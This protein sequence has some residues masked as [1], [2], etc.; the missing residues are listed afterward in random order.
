MAVMEALALLVNLLIGCV[1][2][3]WLVLYVRGWR[4]LRR[5]GAALASVYRLGVFLVATTLVALALFSPMHVLY[6]QYLFIR[7]L[8]TVILYL[9]AAPAFF[10]SCAYDVMLW[11]LPVR[12]R[13]WLY[14]NV[15]QRAP[16]GHYVRKL[17]PPGVAWLL[18]VAAFVI[19]QEPT[20]VNWSVGQPVV[21]AIGLAVVG[22]LALLFWWQIAGSGPRLHRSLLP[23]M[24]AVMLLITEIVNMTTGISIA[25]STQPFYAHYAA[26]AA[27][28]PQR[29]LS[30]VDDQ[31]LA[32]A[33]IWVPGSFVYVTAIVLVLNRLFIKEG[34]RPEPYANWDDDERMIMPGLEHRVKR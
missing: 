1:L 17:M 29:V 16:L 12:A 21:H 10:L 26:M 24:C 8:Q 9:M 30:A 14:H 18:F 5:R 32:G 2:V 15:N 19:W 11:G 23:W 3:A 22:F 27:A 20:F 6:T 34:S 4:R 7:S 33:I 31:S 13:K 28:N 25:F